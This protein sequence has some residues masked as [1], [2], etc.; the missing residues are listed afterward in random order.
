MSP[1]SS[2]ATAGAG[3]R[4][5]SPGSSSAAS[6]ATTANPA[7]ARNSQKNSP[8]R[9]CTLDTSTIETGPVPKASTNLTP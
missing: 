3:R 7:S 4:T 1:P 8:V 9:A 6:V 5:G 2:A